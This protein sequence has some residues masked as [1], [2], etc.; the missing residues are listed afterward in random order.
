M[1]TNN[2]ERYAEQNLFAARMQERIETER[3]QTHEPFVTR[4]IDNDLCRIRLD[5]V[6]SGL[7]VQRDFYLQKSL[8]THWTGEHDQAELKSFC[9]KVATVLQP[10]VVAGE[11]LRKQYENV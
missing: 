8:G 10:L 3:F 4:P 9:G 2:Y 1:S 6:L 7:R 11:E 5:T